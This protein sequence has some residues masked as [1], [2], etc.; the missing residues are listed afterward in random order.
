MLNPWTGELS[1]RPDIIIS[2]Y[3]KY[4]SSLFYFGVLTNST[5]YIEWVLTQYNF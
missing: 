4:E 5:E 1:N 3:S 2:I